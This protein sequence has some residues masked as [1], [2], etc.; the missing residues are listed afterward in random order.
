MKR[1]TAFSHRLALFFATL[2]GLGYLPKAP[3]TYGSF[4]GL[5]LPILL[6]ERFS[7]FTYSIG[8]SVGVVL[9][10]VC[11]H[12]AETL[13]GENDPSAVILDEF[14]AMPFCFLGLQPFGPPGVFWLLGFGLFRFFDI[15]KPL[16]IKRLQ[17]LPGGLGI[18]ADDLAAALCVHCILRAIGLAC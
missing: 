14:I 13:L 5:A 4:V 3:G 1:S 10:V 8:L 11:C 9:S 17:S 15:L 18:V 2:G 7:L 6:T 12:V 16:G